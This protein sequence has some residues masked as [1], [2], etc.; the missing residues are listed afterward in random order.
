MMM[1]NKK[2]PWLAPGLNRMPQKPSSKRSANLNCVD[3]YF[4][5]HVHTYKV[6]WC[7]E[8]S[9]IVSTF[10]VPASLNEFHMVLI[11]SC[12]VCLWAGSPANEMPGFYI[13][14][15]ADFPVMELTVKRNNSISTDGH[16]C[17]WMILMQQVIPHDPLTPIYHSELDGKT[18][19]STYRV[20]HLLLC[21]CWFMCM[22]LF[23]C[24]GNL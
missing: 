1:W 17:N 23:F 11:L 4:V 5:E 24:W 15:K 10:P 21:R 8:D 19:S 2:S 14:I 18:L 16:K 13:D 6:K 20:L 9:A 12:G 7:T 22:T 3:V